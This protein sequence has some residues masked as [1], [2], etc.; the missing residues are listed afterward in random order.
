M[1]AMDRFQRELDAWRDRG[2]TARSRWE[3]L[4]VLASTS[5]ADVSALL[6]APLRDVALATLRATL[7]T[8]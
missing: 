8:S 3:R 5:G 4:V 7:K 6:D 2:R 1:A